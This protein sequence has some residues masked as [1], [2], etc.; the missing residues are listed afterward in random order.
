MNVFNQRQIYLKIM[1][2][3]VLLT[4]SIKFC[5][6]ETP[7]ENNNYLLNLRQNLISYEISPGII[8]KENNELLFNINL[9]PYD[10]NFYLDNS[11]I[12]EIKF[13]DDLST[14][15]YFDKNDISVILVSFLFKFN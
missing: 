13:P 11:T 14:D 15:F 3:L 12:F 5:K 1:I 9:N 10:E 6:N 2:I 7:D 8:N 4:L